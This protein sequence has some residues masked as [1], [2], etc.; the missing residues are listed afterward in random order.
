MA[1]STEPNHIVRFG[2]FELD[3]RTGELRSNGHHIILQEK[4]FQILTALLER[5]GEMVTREELIKRL[6][7][8]GTFVDFELGLNKAVNRLHESLNDSAEQPR[9]IETFPKHGYRLVAV[10]TRNGAGVAEPRKV[11]TTAEASSGA[12]PTAA[13]H[14][15]IAKPAPA[16]RFLF[17]LAVALS[18]ACVLAAWLW[19]RHR[20]AK[21]PEPQFQRL[22][23]GRGTILSARFAPDGQSVVY[24]AA[25]DGKP[26][27]LFYARVGSFESRALGLDADIL[28]IS[29][30]GEMAVLLDQHFGQVIRQGTLALMALTGSAP[31]KLLDNVQDADWSPDGSKLAITHYVGGHCAL[32]FPPGKVLYQT[33]GGAWLSNPR[34][35]PRGDQ[36][37]FLEH[38]LGRGDDAGY[39]A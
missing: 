31:R 17:P 11:G 22:S 21:P 13:A 5:P 1:Y 37:A 36:I 32:E 25:W 29:P 28:A 35:S 8:A 12:G 4:P 33:T 9:F 24:G 26:F 38:P 3:L 20:D 15:P 39:L 10:V 27:Q 30:S 19:I 7:P 18:L 34:V 6:W 14:Q 2:E 23:F 16:R